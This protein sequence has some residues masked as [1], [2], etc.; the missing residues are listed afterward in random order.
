MYLAQGSVDSAIQAAQISAA[1]SV[2]GALFSVVIAIYNNRGHLKTEEKMYVAK[3]YIENSTQL[4][5][6]LD[7]L[8]REVNEIG[9]V[10]SKTYYHPQSVT[11]RNVLNNEAYKSLK[12]GILSPDWLE[13]ERTVSY[14]PELIDSVNDLRNSFIS[15]YSL[16]EN[17]IHKPAK[18]K[19]VKL[20]DHESPSV[21]RNLA[22]VTINLQT[23]VTAKIKMMNDD[24]RSMIDRIGEKF[25]K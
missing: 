14:Y 19:L 21:K 2:L 20:I 4:Q 3:V 23:L 16:L 9:E 12:D 25:K 7:K 22:E 8:W 17:S 10:I 13:I 5:E 24:N 1:A 11:P 18:Y 6:A 15:Y